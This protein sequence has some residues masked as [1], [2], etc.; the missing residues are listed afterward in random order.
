M[1]MHRITI[2]SILAVVAT[3]L[4]SATAQQHPVVLLDGYHNDQPQPHYRWE[5]TY[6]GGYSEFGKLLQ[7]LGAELRTLRE[8]LTADRL[9]GVTCLI[10]VN[11]Y[12]RVQSADPKSIG[13]DEIVAVREWVRA[14]GLLVLLGND[15]GHM[16][17]EH[18]NELA[19]EFGL[20]F[21]NRKHLN[22]QGLSHLTIPLAG[23]GPYFGAGGTAY[24]VD[25]APL[26]V[27]AP[28]A[29]TLISDNNETISELVAFGQGRV[30]ALGDPWAYNEYI[31]TRDNHALVE[32][33]FRYLFGAE[34]A[35]PPDPKKPIPFDGSGV[36]PGPIHLEA[37]SGSVAVS[38]PD[39]RSRTWTATFSLLP[40]QPLI[41]A[42]A[43]D[44]KAVLEHATPVYR[45][46]TGKRHGGWDEFF[47]LP[48]SHP[49]GTREFWAA[50]MPVSASAQ[51]VGN[52]LQIQFE[53]L[54]AGILQGAVR[55]TFYPG[56]RL[57][58]QEAVVVTHEPDTAILY[59]AGLRLTNAP[60]EIAYYDT[61]GQLQRTL[62]T[63]PQWNPTQVRYRAL[64]GTLS[65]GSVVVFPAPHQYFFPRDRTTN[66]AYV[67]HT[68]FGN[69]FGLGIR[70]PT[71]DNT[72]FYP[73]FSAPPGSEQHLGV[74]FLLSDAAPADSL[75][76]VLK[77]TNSD[78]FPTVDG[79]KTVTLHWHFGYTVEA[80]QKGFDWVP[81]FKPVLKDMGVN[82]A[83][84]ADFHG[85]GHP[86]DLNAV[87]LQELDNFFRGCRAQSDADFL[88]FPGEEADVHLGGHWIG[89]FP[90]PVYWFMGRPEGT[91][92]ITTDAQ[93]G[94]VYHVGDEHDMFNLIRQEDAFVYTTHPR[95]KGSKGYPDA[96]RDKDFYLDSHFFG[97]SW[98]DINVDLSSPRLG[99]RSLNLLNDMSNW[100]QPKKI[101]AEVDVF[102][103][104]SEDE[105]YGHMNA[106]Y[107]RMDRLPD[108]DH[109]GAILPPLR[110][111][112]FFV[113]TGEVLLPEASIHAGANGDIVVH[114]RVR[115]TLP[116]R[117]AEVVWGDGKNTFNETISL[118]KTG[119]F[120]DSTF[121]WTVQ[122]GEWKWARF[123]VWDIASDGAFI[124]PIL[125]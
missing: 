29:H 108:F 25:V 12:T 81:P 31:N 84:L 30:L 78:R 39:E 48:P 55:Y 33:L 70:Q 111:G 100:G 26:G 102:K 86:R 50:F 122:A 125:R 18:F 71:D 99:D 120:G 106:N 27:S 115:W 94:K 72:S 42:I 7:S 77:F 1:I 38:W 113:S 110:R 28:H 17:L 2:V 5:G 32:A 82:V 95:T 37:G 67:W 15:P 121:D 8:P 79:Y 45:C 34:A 61:K 87:R 9:V 89:I 40:G 76:E 60:G 63:G 101:L 58:H 75:A 90:K 83:V 49:E 20:E 46:H 88:M 64:A 43:V 65:G 123:A 92:F 98:K 44:G 68:K 73:W 51:T 57:L 54:K 36:R 4:S 23:G 3:G 62:S 116:L 19:R 93:Y 41:A 74:F 21:L 105:L 52:R 10:I 117:F 13:R 107:V 97:G 16:E 24:F 103:I 6:P 96:Y 47:D 53:G 35:A 104:S 69:A 109:Y 59:D 124:N 119:P 118:E 112:D 80:M 66:L 14:G 91:P 56:M 22:T 11:P 85:D 114:A